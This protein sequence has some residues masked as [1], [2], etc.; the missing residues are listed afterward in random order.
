M[1]TMMIFLVLILVQFLFIVSLENNKVEVKDNLETDYQRQLDA[2][3][4]SHSMQQVDNSQ[5][6]QVEDKAITTNSVVITETNER[7]YSSRRSDDDDDD[8]NDDSSNDP[9]YF[10]DLPRTQTPNPNLE[11]QT[12]NPDLETLEEVQNSINFFK[13]LCEKRERSDFPPPNLPDIES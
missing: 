5:N 4:A 10:P 13:S 6:I 12:P 7:T 9:V 1:L 3:M 11:T 2:Y 8:N